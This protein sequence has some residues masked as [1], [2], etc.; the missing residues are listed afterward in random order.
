MHWSTW[1]KHKIPAVVPKTSLWLQ[2]PAIQAKPCHIHLLNTQGWKSVAMYTVFVW[3]RVEKFERASLWFP[4]QFLH[5]TEIMDEIRSRFR[6]SVRRE[7]C[8]V[9]LWFESSPRSAANNQKPVILQLLAS[10]QWGRG[11]LSRIRARAQQML[12]IGRRCL[13]LRDLDLTVLLFPSHMQ[14]FIHLCSLRSF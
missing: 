1:S 7:L 2:G 12:R 5:R 10:R 11:W 13:H 4:F 6:L 8:C 14:L 9:Y 3:A